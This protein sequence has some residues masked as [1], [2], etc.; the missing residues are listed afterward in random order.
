MKSELEKHV[1]KDDEVCYQ[2]DRYPSDSSQ[3]TYGMIQT[4]FMQC[5]SAVRAKFNTRVETIHNHKRREAEIEAHHQLV[6]ELPDTYSLVPLADIFANASVDQQLQPST[7][8]FLEKA[9]KLAWRM[10]LTEP[11]LRAVTENREFNPDLHERLSRAD[12]EQST[13]KYYIRPALVYRGACLTRQACLTTAHQQMV[14][15][16]R[17]YTM[18]G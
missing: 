11:A 5:C 17:I 4:L 8:P 3:K 6:K 2:H 18:Q 9:L 16:L 1:G 14:L 15:C 13:I 7:Q 12:E 10:E